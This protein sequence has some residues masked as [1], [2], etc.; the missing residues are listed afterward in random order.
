MTEAPAGE[1]TARRSLNDNGDN[2]KAERSKLPLLAG[3]RLDAAAVPP[4]IGWREMLRLALRTWPFMRP[5]LRHLITL[6]VLGFWGVLAGWIAGLWGMDLITNKVLVGEKLQPLQASVLFLG[7]EYVTTDPQRLGAG[8]AGKDANAGD[9]ADAS[10]DAGGSASSAPELTPQQRRTVRN[11]LLVWT[12]IGSVLATLAGFSIYYYS[13]W[14]WQCVN[15]N[16]RVAMVERAESLSLKHHDEARVGDAIFRVYQDSAMIVNLIQE[17]IVA[18]LVAAYGLLIALALVAAFDPWFALFVLAVMVP[19]AIL[20]VVSTRRIRLRAR[21]NRQAG[22][23]LTSRTQEVFTALK[24]IKANRAETR[25]FRR[26]DED[27]HAALHAAYFLRLDMALVTLAVGTLGGLLLI[28]SEYLMVAWI[29]EERETFLGAAVAAFIGFVIWNYGAFEVARGRVS[30]LAE[31]ARSLLATWM[32]MQD[33]FIALRRAFHLLDLAPEVVDPADP[34]PVPTPI[35]SVAWRGVRF[36]Y[37]SETAGE[38]QGDV[39]KGVDLEAEAGTVTAIVG[40]TGAGKS[41][42]MAL[43]LRLFDPDSGKVMINGEDLR[44]F[45][46][47]DIRSNVAIALQ[48]NVLFADSVAANIAFGAA[49][50]SRAEIEAAAKIADADEFIREM[51]KGYDTELGERGGKLSSGQR[52]RLSIARAVVR[53]SPILVLDEPTAAL[54]ART[55]RRV[56]LNLAE[57]GRAAPPAQRSGDVS[58]KAAKAA[59]AASG[60]RP[61]GRVIFLITHR[62]STIKNAD[63]IAFIKDGRIQEHGTHGDLMA[64]PDGRYRAFVKAEAVAAEQPSARTATG[65]PRQ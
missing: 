27:S 28:G 46:L 45:A 11:R 37:G 9:E 55:E 51:P 7:S 18:P 1:T 30:G 34:T 40:A 47:D 6:L 5:M 54:D 33:L 19:I 10:V 22:S 31:G 20:A 53:N 17:G 59:K 65:Q 35:T 56:L 42:L 25:V 38:G 60:K 3:Y 29:I 8:D 44:A 57:W 26:F 32:R 16:L 64:L 39:L 63:R 14:I 52:Q 50:A 41:T 61:A 15:Q 43:L 23:S 62:L 36:A 13:V 49:R 21:D 48:K 2:T 4:R 58:G 12:V 24:V